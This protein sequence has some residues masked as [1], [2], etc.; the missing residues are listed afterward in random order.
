MDPVLIGEILAGLMFFGVIAFLLLGFPRRFH[1]GGNLD[2]VCLRRPV[3]RRF[4]H[5]ES[6]LSG[7][8]FIPAT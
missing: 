1:V 8:P 2:P 6:A 4:R 7:E 5:V 3:F